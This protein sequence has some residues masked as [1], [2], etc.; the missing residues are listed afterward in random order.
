MPELRAREV[1]REPAAHR[2][3]GRPRVAPARR[4]VEPVAVDGDDREL[5]RDEER[6]GED[7]QQDGQEAEEVSIEWVGPGASRLFGGAAPPSPA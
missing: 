3:R 2:H 4:A 6:R 5:G 1:E 7:Q